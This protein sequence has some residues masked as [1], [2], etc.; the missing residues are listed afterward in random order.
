MPFFQ[1]PETPTPTPTTAI[2]LKGMTAIITG[3]NIGLGYGTARQL[4]ALNV[5]TLILAVRNISKG[6]TAKS[7]LLADRAHMPSYPRVN[8]K[9][10]QLDLDDYNSVTE[11]VAKV[12]TEVPVLHLLVLNA[13][14]MIL[15]LERSPSGHERTMQVNYLSNALLACELLPLLKSTAEQTGS[16]SR[17]TWVGSRTHWKTSLANEFPLQPGSSIFEHFD[18]EKKFS[19]DPRSG[20]PRYGDTKL[21]CT[22]FV[23]ELVKRVSSK[24]VII[25]IM[26]PGLVNTT[27][28]D[29]LPI[30]LRV[31]WNVWKKIRAR[32]VEE[33]SRFIVH[34]IAVAGRETHGQFLADKVISP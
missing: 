31:P 1:P 16:P 17:I 15:K 23:Y 19:G 9:V 10:M 18:D 4:L 26:C 24:E 14:V 3:A 6:E 7:N 25:N 33:G 27:F 13:G 5:E 20:V 2:D 30:Y 21:L 22:M 29:V 12:K 32:T 11:F 28:S 34:S 8:I